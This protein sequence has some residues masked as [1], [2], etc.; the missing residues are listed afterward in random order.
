MQTTV[1]QEAIYKLH[2]FHQKKKKKGQDSLFP[3]PHH[4]VI[5]LE[6]N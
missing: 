4:I 5:S 1:Q 3:M 2:C 6:D